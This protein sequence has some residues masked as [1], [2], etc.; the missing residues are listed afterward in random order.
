YRWRID[1]RLYK[2][3]YEP[4]NLAYYD[5]LAVAYEKVGDHDK[6]IET[7]R[8]KDKKKPGVYETKSNLGTFLMLRADP[9]EGLEH[10]D[11][12]LAIN[13][14]GHFGREKY[15]KELAEYMISRRKDGKTVLP[16]YA[17]AD[18][19]DSFS[20]AA[21]LSGAKPYEGR[22]AMDEGERQRAVKGVLGMMRF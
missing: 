17:E 4:D 14:D 10:I 22:R 16:L 8:I 12:S 2:L 21:F 13:P 7:I 19:L 3:K 18:F 1:N 11:S 5:D 6:A 15:Q 9:D 20:F